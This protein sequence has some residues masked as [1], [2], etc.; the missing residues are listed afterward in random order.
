M[1]MSLVIKSH[2]TLIELLSLVD[3]RVLLWM[4]ILYI[5][6][7]LSSPLCSYAI[8]VNMKS[9]FR[10]KD[11]YFAHLTTLPSKYVPGGI[12]H[13]LSRFDKLSNPN[14]E[15][16]KNILKLLGF[17][18]YYSVLVSIFLGALFIAISAGSLTAQFLSL[19][20]LCVLLLNPSMFTN[21]ASFSKLERTSALRRSRVV[22]TYTISWILFASS[23][24]LYCTVLGGSDVLRIYYAY[25][26]SWTAGVF[27]VF[28]PQ[29][30]GVFEFFSSKM[31]FP[32]YNIAESMALVFSYRIFM[33]FMD[34]VIWFLS[35]I[36]FRIIKKG[37]NYEAS[38]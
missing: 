19:L 28:A 37:S 16:S 31:I 15:H 25:F 36:V 38:I 17:E 26:L 7:I 18:Q 21:Q 10:I 13:A 33:A 22:M 24:V 1:L 8:G 5:A 20:I 23:F 11:L 34:L 3:I 35:H 9:N 30:I 2:S 27:A 4:S 32:H 14:K 29:G 6:A 12:W